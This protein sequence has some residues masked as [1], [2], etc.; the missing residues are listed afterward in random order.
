MYSIYGGGSNETS[1][2]AM[3][4][5]QLRMELQTEKI[6]NISIRH[7]AENDTVFASD[8]LSIVQEGDLIIRDLG[9]FVIDVFE[10]IQRKGAFFI[11]FHQPLAT[12]SLIT[13]STDE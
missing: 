3:A 2:Y 8:I 4:R 12:K 10:K 5:V 13:L 7:Y 9:H 1:T 6:H 11:S